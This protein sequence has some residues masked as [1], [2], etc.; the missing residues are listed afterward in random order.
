MQPVYSV[1]RILSIFAKYL[2]G[3]V[4]GKANYT[5]NVGKRTRP[6]LNF[7]GKRRDS[8]QHRK[9]KYRNQQGRLKYYV[10]M[11]T[12]NLPRTVGT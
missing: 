3:Y 4:L 8:L 2:L 12:P 6:K 10:K 5:E 9:G 7:T 1:P 11:C